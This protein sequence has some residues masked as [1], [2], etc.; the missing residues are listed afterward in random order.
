M[1]S[2]EGL[3]DTVDDYFREPPLHQIN[4]IIEGNYRC[5]EMVK[6]QLQKHPNLPEATVSSLRTCTWH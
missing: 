3:E 4:Q 5:V 6:P 1:S 2:E